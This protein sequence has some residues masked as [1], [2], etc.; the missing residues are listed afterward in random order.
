MHNISAWFIRSWERLQKGCGAGCNSGGNIEDS[1]CGGGATSLSN[2]PTAHGSQVPGST[3]HSAGLAAVNPAE[4]VVAGAPPQA[5]L[6]P[7]LPPLSQSWL[8]QPQ[9]ASLL[10]QGEGRPLP[11]PAASWPPGPHFLGG[12]L[13]CA[14]SLAS[15]AEGTGRAPLPLHPGLGAP[16]AFA[17]EGLC[18]KW[19]L[20][21]RKGL[22]GLGGGESDVPP[23][24]PPACTKE[25]SSLSSSAVTALGTTGVAGSPKPQPPTPG[26]VPEGASNSTLLPP[27]P[28]STPRGT[29]PLSETAPVVAEWGRQREE[30]ESPAAVQ[31]LLEHQY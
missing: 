27:E 6:E 30:E 29:C 7:G 10:S 13:S 23:G 3:A 18:G 1:D 8:V 12:Q 21:S 22:N 26:P 5:G 25:N 31:P 28:S 16:S 9:P 14:S 20:P 15:V 19:S 24:T 11:T 2:N 4:P 17:Y